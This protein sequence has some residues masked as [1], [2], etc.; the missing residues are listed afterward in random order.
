MDCS[1]HF[2]R[3][4]YAGFRP[5]FVLNIRVFKLAAAHESFINMHIIIGANHF[6]RLGGLKHIMHIPSDRVLSVS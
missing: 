4:C 5:T 6:F 3:G 2:H 1:H